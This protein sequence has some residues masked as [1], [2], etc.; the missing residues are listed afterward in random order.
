MREAAAYTH[1][2]PNG[3][4]Q[5]TKR[6]LFAHQTQPAQT[7]SQLT[8]Q[9]PR[10]RGWA[11]GH[12]RER[13][14]AAEPRAP[15]R[16]PS[17]AAAG[18]AHRPDRGVLLPRPPPRHFYFLFRA[19]LPLFFPLFFSLFSPLFPLVFKGAPQPSFFLAPNFPLQKMAGRESGRG[20]A[21]KRGGRRKTT[22]K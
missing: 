16:A 12:G 10:R 1:V 7:F 19:S 18:A 13:Q 2:P 6:A 22:E 8:N 20:N 15:L 4:G 21:S 11:G 9:R 17:L 5:H 3:R 14:V